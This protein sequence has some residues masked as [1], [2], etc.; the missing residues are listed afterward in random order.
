MAAG[1]RF[2]INILFYAALDINHWLPVAATTAG[3][4]AFIIAK[5]FEYQVQNTGSIFLFSFFLSDCV[6]F[7]WTKF[8]VLTFDVTLLLL[9]FLLAWGELWFLDVRVLPLELRASELVGQLA[10]GAA[11]HDE[12]TP[13]L[14][15]GANV[16]G[17]GAVAADLLRR[18]VEGGSVWGESV[19]NFYS[20]L[21]SPE[22]SGDEMEE[23]TMVRVPRRFKR[24]TPLSQKVS[25]YHRRK[26]CYAWEWCISKGGFWVGNRCVA[27]L[28]SSFLNCKCNDLKLFSDPK[29]FV[30]ECLKSR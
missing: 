3:T 9:S 4:S 24:K 8:G 23:A 15:A 2:V 29:M 5:V 25:A 14:G 26:S 10:G 19:A 18:C 17:N 28:R 21:E 12:R 27:L 7:Q 30:S 20:P 6:S 1:C 11:G 22:D 13:L 16:N